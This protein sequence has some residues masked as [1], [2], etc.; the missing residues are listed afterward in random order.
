MESINSILT[1]FPSFQPNQVLTSK[2][3]NDL[4]NYLE[5]QHRLTRQK[6]IG[7]GIVCGL[8]V[9]R[10]S[11]TDRTVTI[12]KG[13]GI[14]SEGYL[15][16]LPEDTICTHIRPFENRANYSPFIHP[17]PSSSYSIQ[18]LLTTSE[19]TRYSVTETIAESDLSGDPIVVLYLEL[20]ETAINK[21]L[22]E[23]CDEKGKN[24]ELTI[25]KLLIA[26]SDMENIIR[27]LHGSTPSSSFNL[28][29]QLPPIY[30]ERFGYKGRR[31]DLSSI[32]TLDKFV[33]GYAEA[34]QS[35]GLRL[36]NALHEL[37]ILFQPLF[38]LQLGP[39]Q[40]NPF[41]GFDESDSAINPFTSDLWNIISAPDSRLAVQYVYDHILD[42]KATY[43][44]LVD[45]LFDLTSQ[46]CPDSALFPSHLMLGQAQDTS[47]G[48]FDPANIYPPIIF[49]HHF[50]SAP[51][52]NNQPDLLLNI[53]QLIQRLVLLIKKLS[54]TN[55]L[56]AK[57]I[58][59]TPSEDCS[60][61][62]GKQAIPYYYNV[63]T[64]PKPLYRYWDFE[65]SK[66]T[67]A[68]Q[69]LS[70]YSYDYNRDDP[71]VESPLHYGIC[72]Y[73]KLR[74][75]GHVGMQ[76]QKAIVR[77][78]RLRQQYNLPFE[79]MTLKL[80]DTNNYLL[81][82]ESLI[83]DLQAQYLVLRNELVCCL[84]DL[85]A[86]L[87][88][89]LKLEDERIFRPLILYYFFILYKNW[90][91]P[92]Y[93]SLP[94]LISSRIGVIVQ[95]LFLDFYK[96]YLEALS[97]LEK[98]LTPSLKDFSVAR[99][100][101]AHNLVHAMSILVKSLI[102]SWG[103]LSLIPWPEPEATDPSFPLKSQF[104]DLL[105]LVLN[106]VEL[107]LAQI[108]E[109]CLR[110]KF[111]TLYEL[112]VN[113]VERIGTLSQFTQEVHGLEH[114]AG[115]TKGGTFILVYEDN[116]PPTE[117]GTNIDDILAMTERFQSMTRAFQAMGMGA[118]VEAF[119]QIA[120]A[121]P[122]LSSSIHLHS[123]LS[124]S[125]FRVI[126]DFY[127]PRPLPCACLEPEPIE[128][129]AE[130]GRNNLPDLQSF[131]AKLAEEIRNDAN[132]REGAFHQFL[133]KNQLLELLG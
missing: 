16:C 69:L 99:F 70:Y 58:I 65:A 50:S 62:L 123:T 128:V 81:A 49:R 12:S 1:A 61:P 98:A 71:Q 133:E 79:V 112:F 103:D 116:S 84:R 27:Q 86:I 117:T 87:Q 15:I 28:Q 4:A 126:G 63:A 73:P 107:F 106:Y 121:P 40:P 52:Y 94:N 37:Y 44:E 85:I 118:D 39:V 25:R 89:R 7:I 5:Q 110:A 122:T 60:S 125:S 92:N 57:E 82:D 100:Q 80:N 59:I 91:Y 29:Y 77:L 88:D 31:L 68:R 72:N 30:I 64:D 75:E 45:K 10:T 26:E 32:T 41:S 17:T 83:S 104:T 23:S 34:I 96:L 97:S 95:Q 46:C 42:L 18:E 105:S 90:G 21:C 47:P 6:L 56:N 53:Q 120:A 2:H 8:E 22:D 93:P 132:M 102:N 101:A 19:A 33:E 114:I 129:C 108:G 115:T 24:W 20:L 35:G 36:A 130:G 38:N 67:Q 43:E 11:G 109:N 54:F 76:L 74:I 124:T 48:Q 131:I 51:I 119:S 9:H 127:L 14:T 3:L 66:R 55:R 13:V 111:E 78:N 113:R